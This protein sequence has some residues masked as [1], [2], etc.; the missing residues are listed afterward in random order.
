MDEGTVTTHAPA[1]SYIIK[2]PRLT[3]LLNESEAR[4]LLLLAPAGYGK[5]VLARQWA[6]EQTGRSAWVRLSTATADVVALVVTVAQALDLATA[7]GRATAEDLVIQSAHSQDPE[8]LARALVQSREWPADLTLIL[9]DYHWLSGAE[10]AENFM[11][12]L[13]ESLP[14]RILITSRERPAWLSPRLTIYG[15]ALEVGQA[16]LAMTDQEA[17]EVF[18]N[19]SRLLPRALAEETRGW[20]VVIALA[21]RTTRGDLPKRGV[22]MRL[23][24]Y[25]AEDMI[26]SASEET[27][28]LLRLLALTGITDVATAIGPLGSTEMAI[29]EAERR[30]L[31][32]RDDPGSVAIHPLFAEF[33]V[34]RLRLVDRAV[35]T[36]IVSDL[37][38]RLLP[39]CRWDECLCVA[40]LFP[41]AFAEFIPPL[42]HR[43]LRD[44][45]RTGRVGTVERWVELAR[46]HSVDDVI[47]DIADGEVA[48]REGNFDRAKALAVRAAAVAQSRDVKS[49]SLLLAAQAAHLGDA[50]EDAKVYFDAA[51]ASAESPVVL[52]QARWGQFLVKHEDDAPDLRESLQRFA[53][54]HDGS[55]EHSLRVAQGHHL[56]ALAGGDVREAVETARAATALLDDC[57][58]PVIRLSTLNQLAWALNLAALYDEALA[59]VDRML[60]EARTTGMRF[61]ERYGLVAQ[62]AALTGT[63]QF[64]RARQVI[65]QLRSGIPQERDPWLDATIAIQEARFRISTGDLQ[66]AESAL[67][68]APDP[69]LGRTLR[70]EHTAYRGIVA[71]AI[72]DDDRARAAAAEAL[73]ISN[74]VESQALCAIV[75][76]ISAITRG[77]HVQARERLA[78][79]FQR[80]WFDAFVIGIRAD[81]RLA[82]LASREP[83]RE[84]LET[85]L[86]RSRDSSIA[87]N[88]NLTISRTRRAITALSPREEEVYELMAQGRTNREIAKT[89][90]ISE[91]TTKVHVRHILEKLGVRSRVDAARLAATGVLN[92]ERDPQQ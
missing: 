90:F 68:D 13:A 73:E 60:Q 14:L 48:L 41:E 35:V 8:A 10:A 44:L 40:Q 20:P 33:V 61:A 22:P 76:V 30:G 66:E 52:A 4:I 81:P 19:H 87:R 51:V 18:R 36:E 92:A 83:I 59:Q 69:R 29:D 24:S 71:A 58:D 70:A 47:V 64:A 84:P 75:D 23:Y 9:D 17:S 46:S 63:R 78:R 12:S 74:Q 32:T 28:A 86:V 89:L 15:E 43:A 5:T 72:G 50:H 79:I 54:A 80:E 53:D 2:R 82:S 38:R 88:L 85:L 65:N 37:A 27:I 26:A 1:Q 11:G 39:I 57:R 25:L 91:S 42:L 67:A 45:L 3:K 49:H 62:S 7:D 16:E 34:E 55:F 6:A 56:I 21:A 77:A 31:V